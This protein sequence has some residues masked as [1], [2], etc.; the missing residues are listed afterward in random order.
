MSSSPIVCS[1]PAKVILFGEQVVVLGR[2]AIATALDLRTYA[3]IERKND[4]NITI[5]LPDLNTT[6][7]WSLEEILFP[8][9]RP[10][11]NIWDFSISFNENLTCKAFFISDLSSIVSTMNQSHFSH[12]SSLKMIRS[13]HCNAHFYLK[14]LLI[15]DLMTYFPFQRTGA[16]PT[17]PSLPAEMLQFIDKLAP[18]DRGLQAFLFLTI[19]ISKNAPQS[20]HVTVKSEFQH[21]VGLGS[22]AAYNVALAAALFQFFTPSAISLTGATSRSWTKSQKPEKAHALIINSWAFN[23]EKLMHGTPSGIDNSVSTFGGAVSLKKGVLDPIEKVPKLNIVVTNTQV[24][25][26]TKVLVAK[27]G[28]LYRRHPTVVEPLL[29]SV[30][31]ISKSVLELFGK[32]AEETDQTKLAEFEKTIE[33]Y[34]DVN[35]HVLVALGVGHPALAR[36]VDTGAKFGV[37]S[38]LTGAGGGGC[39]FSLIP[40]SSVEGSGP[41]RAALQAEGF[42][43]FDASTGAVGVLVHDPSE[44]VSIFS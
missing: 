15:L 27:V 9:T 19:C 3:K 39:A 5:E 22:S 38:K 6:N 7:S 34:I 16:V 28:D 2:T 43:C 12:F 23:A 20:F 18:N 30:E 1:A 32:F 11:Q 4:G 13:S 41:L 33:D 10:R 40:S 36:V 25:R 17:E 42:V 26:N 14:C 44:P 35:H 29:D 21:G 8:G 37:H 31:G 24:S